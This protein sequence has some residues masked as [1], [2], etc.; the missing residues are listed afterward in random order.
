MSPYSALYNKLKNFLS[1]YYIVK[2]IEV[3]IYNHMFSNI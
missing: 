1:V 3:Y 2:N